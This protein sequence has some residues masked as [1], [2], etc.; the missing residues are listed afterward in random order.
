MA[1]KTAACS[2]LASPAHI[3][4]C[5]PCK[6]QKEWNEYFFYCQTSSIFCISTWTCSSIDASFFAMC[7][8]CILQARRGCTAAAAGCIRPPTGAWGRTLAQRLRILA[9]IQPMVATWEAGRTLA[10][11]RP[12]SLPI[13]PSSLPI[14]PSSLPIRPSSLGTLAHTLHS[15][16]IPPALLSI[17]AAAGCTLVCIL[18][19]LYVYGYRY[20]RVCILFVCVGSMNTPLVFIFVFLSPVIFVIYFLCCLC[21]IERRSADDAVFPIWR[22][23]RDVSWRDARYCFSFCHCLS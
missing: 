23:R 15:L 12:S 10:P 4:V 22:Q 20:A 3:P 8:T 9:L 5:H 13:R 18:G 7:K 21:G 14:R 19:V 11:I 2:A 6:N 16:H 1:A 17:T